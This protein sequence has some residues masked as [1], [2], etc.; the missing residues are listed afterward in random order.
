MLFLLKFDKLIEKLQNIL[1][2]VKLLRYEKQSNQV[3]NF[4]TQGSYSLSLL[5]DL[6]KF[7]IDKT[8]HLKS[9][10]VIECSGGVEIGK[11]VHI[12]RGLTIFSANHNWNEAEKIP[13]DEV[14]ICKK[15]IIEDFVWL[16]A[17]VMILPGVTIAEGAII[18]GGSVVIN[19]VNRGE[20]VGGNPAKVIGNRDLNLFDNLKINQKYH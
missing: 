4:V 1:L 11:Y 19:N 16:G 2:R 5:G 13:Y 15:V 7:K 17:N 12:A 3:I 8:S 10:T 6:K 18:A 20:I 9:D 14:I